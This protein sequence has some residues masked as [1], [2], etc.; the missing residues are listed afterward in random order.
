M[1]EVVPAFGISWPI[2]SVIMEPRYIGF[3]LAQQAPVS[4]WRPYFHV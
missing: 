4:I 2:N 1:G 3:V